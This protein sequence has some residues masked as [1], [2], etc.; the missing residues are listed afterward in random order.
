MGADERCADPQGCAEALE[1]LE[2][3]LDGELPADRLDGI[4]AHLAACYPCTDRASF[5]EQL[6]AIVRRECVDR[7]PASLRSR[8]EGLLEADASSGTSGH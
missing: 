1:K 4:R 2:A 3:Y 6:R 5:E 8:I 7:A